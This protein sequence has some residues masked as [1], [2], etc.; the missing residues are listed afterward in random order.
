[1]FNH[2]FLDS[3]GALSSELESSIT[4]I[5]TNSRK[6]SQKMELLTTELLSFKVQLLESLQNLLK[7]ASSTL[8]QQTLPFIINAFE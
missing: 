5:I 4:Q 8:T 7:T 2:T 3:W 6:I 1:M